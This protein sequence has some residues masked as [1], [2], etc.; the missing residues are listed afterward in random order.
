MLTE[1]GQVDEAKEM[2]TE[3]IDGFKELDIQHEIE[4]IKLIVGKY[5]S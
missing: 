2:L 1:M 5:D 4:H 3:A